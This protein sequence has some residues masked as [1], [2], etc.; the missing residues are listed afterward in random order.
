MTP[1]RGAD[2]VGWRTGR[3]SHPGPAGRTARPGRPGLEAIAVSKA[4]KRP[5]F[6]ALCAGLLPG[7]A[8]LSK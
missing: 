5:V 6:R 2:R 7:I 8:A 3:R 4:M 1:P